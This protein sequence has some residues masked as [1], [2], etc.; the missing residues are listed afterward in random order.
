MS[1]GWDSGHEPVIAR[2]SRVS[3]RF[4]SFRRVVLSLFL[5]S[6]HSPYYYLVHSRS[7]SWDSTLKDPSYSQYVQD[8]HAFLTNFAN[9]SPDAVDILVGMLTPDPARRMGLFQVRKMVEKVVS[10][11]VGEE[12]S[13]GGL[14]VEAPKLSW[15]LV[16]TSPLMF[17]ES[18]EFERVVLRMGFSATLDSQVDP[19][20]FSFFSSSA[21]HHRSPIDLESRP[22]RRTTA[23]C[24]SP[25]PTARRK[26][27]STRR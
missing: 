6:S 14:Q 25:P 1:G 5:S 4:L 20:N 2:T 21:V 9:F 18:E 16:P 11:K 24:N 3:S 12:S 27:S 8:P 7:C 10:W 17:S 19:S 13:L 15:E 26:R 23:S 22:P